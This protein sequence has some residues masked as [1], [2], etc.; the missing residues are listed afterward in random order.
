MV[1]SVSAGLRLMR[2][3]AAVALLLA[4]VLPAQRLIHEWSGTPRPGGDDRFGESITMIGDL[5][6]DGATEL[7]VSE[8]EPVGAP[9]DSGRIHVYSGR[10]GQQLFELRGTYANE[11]LGWTLALGDVDLDA[12][13][14]WFTITH[15]P[16][17]AIHTIWSGAKRAPILR[18]ANT[19]WTGR[20]DAVGD[21]DRDGITEL[22][23]GD[24]S[25]G[26]TPPNLYLGRVSIVSLRAGLRIADHYGEVPYHGFGWAAPAGDV[27]GD[28][29][30]DYLIRPFGLHPLRGPDVPRFYSGRTH[31]E[32]FRVYPPEP[33]GAFALGWCAAGDLNADGFDDFAASDHGSV[34]VPTRYRVYGFGGPDGRELFRFQRLPPERRFG[35]WLA[36]VGDIDGDAHDDLFVGGFGVESFIHSGRDQSLLWSV[37]DSNLQSY[38]GYAAGDLDG[39]EFPDFVIPGFWDPVRKVNR[40]RAYSGAP[41]GVTTLG[42]GC[43]TRAGVIPRIGTSFTPELGKPFAINLSRVVPGTSAQLVLGSSSTIWNGTPLPLDLTAFGMPGCTLRTSIDAQFVR[44]AQGISHKGWSRF[45]T[46]IPNDPRLRGATFYAQWLVFGQDAVGPYGVTTRALAVTIQ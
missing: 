20:V 8:R 4:S 17:Y 22:S 16:N 41:V 13:P 42:T 46:T 5:D 29:T 37:V 23:F 10:T 38:F 43:A 34:V 7:A 12:V 44:Q 15:G 19:S 14:D 35:D 3:G 9:V 6:R 25:Y 40:V 24:H 2:H 26:S 28:G 18:W 33:T 11:N 30:P 31:Q 39:D 1:E 27:N 32:H 45:E 21:L 36:R